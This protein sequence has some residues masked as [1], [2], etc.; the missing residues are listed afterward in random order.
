[1]GRRRCPTLDFG[2]AA[3]AAA[4]KVGAMVKGRRRRPRQREGEGGGGGCAR[5]FVG[6]VVSLRVRIL[7]SRV[8][9]IVRRR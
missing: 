2:A 8:C 4:W 9:V 1:M 5:E 7:S 3:A 6:F